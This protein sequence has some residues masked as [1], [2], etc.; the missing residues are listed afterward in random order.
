MVLYRGGVA[1]PENIDD[2]RANTC[3]HCQTQ[4]Q[5]SLQGKCA[6]ACPRVSTS[7]RQG[8]FVRTP[9]EHEVNSVA[10]TFA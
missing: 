2:F 9:C 4:K 3:V 1:G 6:R 8:A 10:A 7:R 5:F